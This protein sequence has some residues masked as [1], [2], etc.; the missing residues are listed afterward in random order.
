MQ[1][2]ISAHRLKLF[3][4]RSKDQ[5]LKTVTDIC[6]YY[7]IYNYKNLRIK[8]LRSPSTMQC[9]QHPN[10]DHYHYVVPQHASHEK[11]VVAPLPIAVRPLTIL[12]LPRTLAKIENPCLAHNMHYGGP[13]C[14]D[15]AFEDYTE[16]SKQMFNMAAHDTCIGEKASHSLWRFPLGFIGS[17]SG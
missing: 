3:F 11:L 8:A 14:D 15:P 2:H 9:A 7:D 1:G 17:D 13:I 4:F 16:W 5:I 6:L 10:P 12:Y